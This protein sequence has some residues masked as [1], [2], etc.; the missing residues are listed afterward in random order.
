MNV[1]IY[2]RKELK[3]RLKEEKLENTLLIAFYDPQ[4]NSPED[5]SGKAERVITVPIPDLDKEDLKEYGY[6]V[7]SYFTQTDYVAEFIV[8]AV[9]DGLDIACACE[10]GESRSAGCAAAIKEFFEGNGI[11]IFADER[12]YPNKIIY[13]KLLAALRKK[14]K[15]NGRCFIHRLPVDENMGLALMD[16]GYLSAGKKFGLF[17][18]FKQGDTVFVPLANDEFMAFEVIRTTQGI[19][20][21][22]GTELNYKNKTANI[23]KEGVLYE[24]EMLNIAYVVK[25]KKLTK[26]RAPRSV[27]NEELRMKMRARRTNEEVK[28]KT[29]LTGI[30]NGGV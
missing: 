2:S 19:A 16:K 28:N 7:D 3:D 13:N 8:K 4:Y 17:C 27:L 5:F 12:Y 6:T 23:T 22:S 10:Y 26:K 18:E 11:E 21:L 9:R 30:D 1:K 20:A 29:V 14:Q 25:V 15:Q 24:D